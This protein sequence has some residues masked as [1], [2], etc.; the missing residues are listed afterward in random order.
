MRL[1]SGKPKV[2]TPGPENQPDSVL[3]TAVSRG[4]IAEGLEDL[5]VDVAVGEFSG[6]V[7]VVLVV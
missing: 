3:P 2:S 5:S 1:V 7:V 6:F 4:L